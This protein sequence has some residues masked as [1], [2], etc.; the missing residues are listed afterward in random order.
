M[1]LEEVFE[2]E[3]GDI[4]MWIDQGTIH[5]FACDKEY[6]DPI[7]LTTDAARQIAQKLITL[8]DRVEA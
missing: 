6:R 5:L 3:D 1:Q 4:R 7:E 8:A 2:F